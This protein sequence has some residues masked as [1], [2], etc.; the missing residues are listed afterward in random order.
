MDEQ[1]STF[2]VYVVVPR[3]G[4]NEIAAVRTASE[5]TLPATTLPTAT[6]W[7]TE[8]G[9]ANVLAATEALIGQPTHLL[10]RVAHV[11]DDDQR[12]GAALYIAEPQDR[13]P[14]WSWMTPAAIDANSIPEPQRSALD[15]FFEEQMSGVVPAERAGWMRPNWLGSAAAWVEQ[16]VADRGAAVEKMTVVR[17]WSISY[18]ARVDTTAGPYY[19]KATAMRPLFVDEGSVMTGLSALY[20]AIVPRPVAHRP[21]E[22][23]MLMAAFEGQAARRASADAK[24]SIVDAIV[25]LQWDSAENIPA[26]LAAGCID[27]R[28]P[29]LAQQAEAVLHDPLLMGMLDSAEC[30]ALHAAQPTLEAMCTELDASALPDTLVHGDLHLGNVMLR[31]DGFTLYD[32]TDAAVACPFFDTLFLRWNDAPTNERLLN[33]YLKAWSAHIPVPELRRLWRLAQPLL[34]LYHLISYCSLV[35]ATEPSL[36]FELADMMPEMARNLLAELAKQS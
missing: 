2:T 20:P 3:A 27:R 30:A 11:Q 19:F 8:A 25:A 15:A 18:V 21:T 35:R 4:S 24:A 29:L 34:Y 26:L 28:L 10:R 13:V 1:P 17:S 5:W 6:L 33:A 16:Q 12:T 7:E 23:W 36:R 14:G 9:S 31:P 32:W 22:N